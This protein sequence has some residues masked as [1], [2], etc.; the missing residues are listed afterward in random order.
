MRNNPKN[1]YG[2]YDEFAR[3]YRKSI[4][5]FS[6]TFRNETEEKRVGLLYVIIEGCEAAR[7]FNWKP[8]QERRIAD[9]GAI[10]KAR[11]AAK[12]ARGFAQYARSYPWQI[13]FA[14]MK[15]ILKTGVH[16]RTKADEQPIEAGVALGPGQAVRLANL[17]TE[18]AQEIEAGNLAAKAGPFTHRTRH[19]PLLYS[20]PVEDKAD[21]PEPATALAIYL[22]FLFRKFS[23][24]GGIFLQPGET[25]PVRGRP[26]WKLVGR[27]VCD[28][29]DTNGD[30]KDRA[31]KVIRR[32]AKLGMVG[33]WWGRTQENSR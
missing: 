1:T 2:L 13:T 5:R 14:L 23:L 12:H 9:R 29:L 28:A 30:F 15:A 19:G 25:I 10:R 11:S 4:E 32:N 22:S 20:K 26:R 21:L 7:K 8:E 16:L 27:F 3:R 17:L 6:S 33:Y 24:E 18:F 31:S